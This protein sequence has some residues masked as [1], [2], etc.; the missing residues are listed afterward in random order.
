M[1]RAAWGTSPQRGG[2]VWAERV[3]PET[4]C[5]GTGTRRPESCTQKAS[6]GAGLGWRAPGGP[7]ESEMRIN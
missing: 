7:E 4:R 2:C 5:S 1:R 3:D 6:G